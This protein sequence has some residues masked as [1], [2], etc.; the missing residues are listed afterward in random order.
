MQKKKREIMVEYL[1]SKPVRVENANSPF[2]ELFSLLKRYQVLPHGVATLA[3]AAEELKVMHQHIDNAMEILLQGL[4]DLGQLIGIA[5]QDKEK[6][7][8]DLSNI[9]FFISAIG[10]LTEALNALR[11]DADYVLKQ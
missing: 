6:I 9:G 7:A 5:A 8:D 2:S 4:Q 11:L 10:N 3:Y 1:I